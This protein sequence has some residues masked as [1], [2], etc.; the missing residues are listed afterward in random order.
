MEAP[1]K[2]TIIVSN[3]VFVL[4]SDQIRRDAPNYFTAFFEGS[5]KESSEGVRELEIHRDPYLFQFI[6][7]YLTGYEILPLP[8]YDIPRYLS[9]DSRDINLLLD[10]RFYGLDSLA[11]EL[12]A[13]IN[14]I[15]KAAEG[16]SQRGT[17][18]KEVYRM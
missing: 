3:Y 10:A 17:K 16:G 1:I 2:Y 5:F 13:R 18:E 15:T 4:T 12:E 11:Q 14:P 7:A 6:H 8:S 9:E